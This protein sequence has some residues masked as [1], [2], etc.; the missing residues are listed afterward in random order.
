MRTAYNFEIYT[1]GCNYGC[2]DFC[3][4]GEFINKVQL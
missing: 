2:N 3:N 4:Y 1:Y